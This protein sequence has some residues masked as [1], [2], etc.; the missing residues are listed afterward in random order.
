MGERGWSG[1]CGLALGGLLL[2]SPG[3]A[4]Q[5]P[6][7]APAGA[8]VDTAAGQPV[9]LEDAL[10]LAEESSEQVTISQAAVMRAQ[11]AQ[12]Q[13]RSAWFPQLTASAGYTRTLAT[14]FSSVT[15]APVD[16]TAPQNCPTGRFQPDPSLP[17]AQ[18]VDSLEHALACGTGNPFAAFKN[19]PFGRQNQVN[20]GLTF[21]Q[22]VFTGGRIGGL[23]QQ[24]NAT[25]AL[26]DIALASTRAQL[27]L[28]VTQAYYDAALSQRL[29]A[30]AEGALS[31]A[32]RTLAQVRLAREVGNQ[33]EFDLLRAQVTYANQQPV[34]I[35]R[36]AQRDIALLRLK[37]LLNLPADSALRLT[38]PLGDTTP[39]AVVVRL[40][41]TLARNP[42]DTAT[43]QRAPVRQ[44]AASLKAQ[45]GL[46]RVAGSERIPALSIVSQFGRVAYPDAG[47]PAWSD[48]RTNWTVGVSLSVPLFTGGRLRG[49]RMVAAAAV[50][51]ARARLQQTA[52]LAALDTHSALAQ[53]HAAESAFAASAGT[54]Q[55]A[56]KA[57]QIADVRFREGI[58]TQLELDDSRL[59]LQ[60][61]EV[62]RAQAA[63]DLQIAR[64]RMALLPDLPLSAGSSTS[65]ASAAAQAGSAGVLST[66]TN[67]QQSAP[68]QAPTS[69]QTAPTQ[70]TGPSTGG[71]Q[72]GTSAASAS[73]VP[74]NP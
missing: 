68:L 67:P 13:A 59:M 56:E 6:T 22:S 39:P 58:S 42:G 62:N 31:Q 7:E 27:M 8:P 25:R 9:T 43:A 11:G 69:S 41:A 45:E 66:P 21:S 48:F 5:Q 29:L 63:R 19:L 32:Q 73:V 26:A 49:D 18:R 1:L 51:D 72:T 34:V 28:D 16:T 74:T 10:R 24:A 60:Q 65:N 55:Q 61:A 36:R 44:A 54:E 50:L 33:P 4:A 15:S 17:L 46:R 57:Y 71:S 3:V 53:L 40:A 64:I 12:L 70:A 20:L 47:L 23:M 37:Q 38:T 52:E 35:Q 2:S 30:I 14:E